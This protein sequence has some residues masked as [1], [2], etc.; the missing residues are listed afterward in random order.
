MNQDIN[1][2][3]KRILIAVLAVVVI[4][5]GVS[6]AAVPLY[7]LFCQVT[8]F[9]G[10]TQVAAI[11]PE[12]VIDRS[13]TIRFNA[14]TSPH[15]PWV[16]KPAERKIEI[17]LGQRG[18]TA[19]YAKNRSDK[20]VTGMAIYNVTPLKAGKYFHKMQ[21]FCFDE[22]TLQAGEEVNMP[23]LFFVDPAMHDDPNMDDVQSITLSYTFYPAES[24]ALEK[25]LETFYSGAR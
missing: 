20:A 11:L 19:Y 9:G 24:R 15:L 16:F 10:T 17:K 8:G 6:F 2:K 14:V 3:N 5:I 12:N 21:C 4:M 13:V 18:L 25:G 7:R 23:V 22:Q 1:K